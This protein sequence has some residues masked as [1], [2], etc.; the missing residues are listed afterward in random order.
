MR[1]KKFSTA[2]TAAATIAAIATAA[3]LPIAASPSAS[4]KTVTPAGS[5]EPI[6]ALN[7]ISADGT[8][9]VGADSIAVFLNPLCGTDLGEHRT[10]SGWAAQ[11]TPSPACGWL[12]SVVAL[13]HH[14]AWA[15]GDETTSSAAIR[16]VTEFYNGSRW[17]IEPSP[18]PG[19]GNEL[20][21][22]AAT[23]SGTVWAVGMNS[24]GSLILKHLG[25][26]WTQVKTSLQVNLQSVTVTPAGQV[27]AVGSEFDPDTL[28]EA[29][30]IIH[31]TSSGWKQVPSPNPGG[32]NSSYLTAVASGPHGALWAVGYYYDAA[33]FEPHTLTLRYSSGHWTQVASPSPGKQA[34]WLYAAAVSR[35]G[36]VWAVGGFAGPSCEHN[37]VEHFVSGTWHLVSVPNRGTC[38]GDVTNALYGVAVTGGSVYAVGQAGIDSLAEAGGSGGRWKFL[39]SS[40]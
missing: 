27:W 10:A 15:V 34:D 14:K 39:R 6:A 37:L 12:S 4:A 30:A 1:T 16:T 17:Q 11:K 2:A 31:L 22:V 33:N 36:Q 35:S 26:H 32:A 8:I 20:H 21:G 38:A 25:G 13:P 28:A 9:A 24:Q 29:T 3:L 18:N 19:T 5:G 40:N 23:K 7:A